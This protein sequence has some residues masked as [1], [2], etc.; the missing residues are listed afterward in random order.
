MLTIIHPS[1]LEEAPS[2]VA[3]RVAGLPGHGP[4][5]FT[6]GATE[7]PG[8]STATMKLETRRG[9][10]FLIWPDFGVAWRGFWSFSCKGDTINL[11]HIY[12]YTHI[13][14]YIHTQTNIFKPNMVSKCKSRVL[15]LIPRENILTE[16][17]F[18]IQCKGMLSLQALDTFL[19]WRISDFGGFS[20][21]LLLRDGFVLRILIKPL[22]GELSWWV[23]GSKMHA[24]Q[25]GS[26]WVYPE[27][28]Y[29]QWLNVGLD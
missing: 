3:R 8:R 19:R 22:G 10:I 13:Y 15:H 23:A 27:S 6:P 12:I 29:L 11:P 20:E 14:I 1:I 17:Q 7:E 16:T 9:R 2:N 25:R 4:V 5:A 18:H 21:K 26:Q 24:L 28:T